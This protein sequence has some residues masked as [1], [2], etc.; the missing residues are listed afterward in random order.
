[1]VRILLNRLGLEKGKIEKTSHIINLIIVIFS[2][3]HII[4]CAWIAV[5]QITACSWLD[6]VACNG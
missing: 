1:M 6:Q 4:G 2:V 3:I 5:G